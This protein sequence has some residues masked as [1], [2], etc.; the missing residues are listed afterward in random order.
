[1]GKKVT[2]RDV[3]QATGVSVCCV[4]WV[5]NDH[6]RSSVVSEK[7]RQRVLESAEM[8]GYCRNEL[9]SATRTG[10]VNTIAVILNFSE[11]QT[12]AP[13]NQIMT[14]IMFETSAHRQSVKVFSDENLD[15]SF[16]QILESRIGKVIM[17]SV[18]H[19]LRE[20]AAE[21]AEKYSLELV[22]AYEHGH[23]KFPA[24]NV[25]NAE[26]TSKIVHYLKE[27]GHTRIGLLCVPHG[28]HYVRDRHAGYLRGM[29]QCCLEVDP[30]WISCSD[31]LEHSLRNIFALPVRNRPTAF[32]ALSDTVA[33]R[34]QAYAIRN[35]LLFPRD[36]S[37]VGI[38][39]LD[40]A[41]QLP[42]PL[43]TMSESLAETGQILVRLLMKE[44]LGVE[45]DEFNVYH[46][47]A[48][49]IERQSVCN[50]K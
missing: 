11:Y 12:I 25:D 35:S 44:S 4:S 50:I 7:T 16:R 33:A 23:G 29:V 45:P 42:F 43:T 22:Y 17:M 18:E 24:V 8:L 3:A 28:Y 14:G 47:H 36:I 49:L 15:D 37:V 46:T 2:I 26:A 5:L 38:G 19:N 31:E 34:V 20:R 48:V 40:I 41:R 13:F 21:L 1:M 27:M 10:Q 39:N 32:V 9:A 30:R 6:P